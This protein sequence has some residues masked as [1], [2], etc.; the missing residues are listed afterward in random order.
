MSVE[1]NLKNMKRLDDAWNAKDWTKAMGY[2]AKEVTVF[3]PGGNPPT[4]GRNNH[5][6]EAIEFTKT[7]P[8]NRVWNDPYRVQFGQDDWTCT[9]TD[10]TGTMKGPMRTEEGKLVTPTNKGF[11]VEFCTLAR[12]KNGEIVEEKLFYDLMGLLKQIGLM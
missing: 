2:H 7:F 12:W 1:E 8:D 5:E 9:V 3:W 11:K 10:F 6:K 4:K